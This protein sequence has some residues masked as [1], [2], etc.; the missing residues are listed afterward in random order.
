ML[1][2]LPSPS[3]QTA[4]AT[5]PGIAP[6]SHTKNVWLK[7]LLAKL[8]FRHQRY[9]N[10]IIWTMNCLKTKPTNPSQPLK[11]TK[12]LRHISHKALRYLLKHDMIQGIEL[13]S[14]GDKITC[15]VCIKSKITC[16][17]LPKYSGKWAEKLGEKI[18]SDVWGLSRHLTTNKKL[19]YVLFIDDYS[20]ES[21]IYLRR[22]KDQVFA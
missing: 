8:C 18:Y 22:S 15:D 21:V 14:I 11:F 3:S 20:R 16:K 4:N 7:V 2:K 17:S 1:P 6:S 19:Y 13:D 9:M 10:F 12:K 5:M